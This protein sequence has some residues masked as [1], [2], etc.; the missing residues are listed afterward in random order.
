MADDIIYTRE[1]S[2]FQIQTPQWALQIHGPHF[3]ITYPTR[4]NWFFRM[5]QRLLLGW[6]WKPSS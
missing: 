6:K 4:P 3:L 2:T 1:G 5:W